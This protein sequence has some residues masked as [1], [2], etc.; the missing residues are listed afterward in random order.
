MLA[1][2]VLLLLLLLSRS[3]YKNDEYMPVGVDMAEIADGEYYVL[4][5]EK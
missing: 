4:S 5:R 1:L 3:F 2:N